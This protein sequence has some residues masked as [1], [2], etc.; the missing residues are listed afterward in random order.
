[1]I[2]T[3]IYKAHASKQMSFARFKSIMRKKQL[4]IQ[5]EYCNFVSASGLQNAFKIQVMLELQTIQL[6]Q[7][8]IWC[9]RLISRSQP[10][11]FVLVT[12]DII[13]CKNMKMISCNGITGEGRNHIF[14]HNLAET[15]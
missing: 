10:I 2:N 8:R 6:T 9:F 4:H 1:M 13:L 14:S 7:L 11:Y 3:T 5:L 15:A 12:V